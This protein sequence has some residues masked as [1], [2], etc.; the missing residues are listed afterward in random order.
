[1]KSAK[2]FWYTWSIVVAMLIAGGKKNN[3]K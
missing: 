1:M 2:K 3:E